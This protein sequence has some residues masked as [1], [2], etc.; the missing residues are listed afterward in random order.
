MAKND[1]NQEKIQ[2]VMGA[3]KSWLSDEG[4]KCTVDDDG[5]FNIKYQGK[6]ILFI[7][8]EDDPFYYRILMPGIYD[9]EKD[10]DRSR[11]V[12]I[13]NEWTSQRKCLKAFVAR[14]S[15]WI[16]I[17]MFVDPDHCY[18]TT[19]LERMLDIVIDAYYS[20]AKQILGN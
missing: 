11:I 10:E 14:D 13:C 19:Y 7:Q 4:Y 18:I 1:E 8:D 2:K 5:D 17:E 12:E 15:V 16:S 9:I 20:I 6:H 3:V